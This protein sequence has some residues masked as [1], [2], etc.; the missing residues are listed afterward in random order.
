MQ[1]KS[2]IFALIEC[3]N[4]LELLKAEVTLK[5]FRV[6]LEHI[7]LI[8]SSCIQISKSPERGSPVVQILEVQTSVT[9]GWLYGAERSGFRPLALMSKHQHRVKRRHIVVIVGCAQILQTHRGQFYTC[10]LLWMCSWMWFYSF[11]I[12]PVPGIHAMN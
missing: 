10:N 8:L 9:D 12:V 7:S 4:S 5:C 2:V 3:I 1:A 6:W 11:F